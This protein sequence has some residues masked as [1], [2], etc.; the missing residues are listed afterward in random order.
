M[1]KILWFDNRNKAEQEA[2]SMRG[3]QNPHPVMYRFDD[4]TTKWYIKTDN[5]Y[6]LYDDGCMRQ[7]VG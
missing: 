7:P 3:W 2:Q 4:T 6:I 1:Y 5:G